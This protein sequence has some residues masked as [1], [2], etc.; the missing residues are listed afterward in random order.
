[1]KEMIDKIL[2][3][4]EKIKSR[5]EE[6]GRQIEN[7]YRDKDLLVIG[8]LKGGVTF[9]SDLIRNIDLPLLLDY[10]DVSSYEGTTSSGEVKILK[11]LDMPIENKDILIVEDIIDTGNTLNY[12]TKVFK[13]RNARSVK[14]ATLLTKPDRREVEVDVSYVGFEIPDLFVVGYGLDYNQ[15]GRNL[16]FIGVLKEEYYK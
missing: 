11:D 10:M 4:E 14:L 13:S 16:P 12:L 5:V 1:M 9:M 2:L 3:S 15:I 7:D 6:L 8:I